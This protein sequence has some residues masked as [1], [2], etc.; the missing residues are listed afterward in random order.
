MICNGWFHP[1]VDLF[2]TRFNKKLPQFVCT[3]PDSLTWA[4]DAVSLPW[5]DMDAVSLPWED[6]DP[7][8]FPLVAILGSGGKI[9]RLPMQEDNSNRSRFA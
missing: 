4:V 5:E 3:V 8:D 2:A 6:M 9:K 1:Q 7:Y